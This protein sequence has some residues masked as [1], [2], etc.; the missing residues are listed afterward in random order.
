MPDNA[1]DGRRNLAVDFDQVR[2]IFLQDRAHD[3][4]CA[5]AAE[6]ALTRKHLVEDGAEAKKIG[7]WTGT[8]PPQLFWGHVANSAQH[9]IRFR[10]AGESG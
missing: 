3:V 7:C 8:L 9:N 2:R 5:G 1:F 10:V 4:G 6:C